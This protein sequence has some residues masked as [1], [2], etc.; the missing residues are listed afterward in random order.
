MIQNLIW[1]HTRL[2]QH[3]FASQLTWGRTTFVMLTNLIVV[4]L[5]L[6]R[7]SPTCAG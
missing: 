7:R 1:N 6:F 3:Q 2:Q 4:T 5:G